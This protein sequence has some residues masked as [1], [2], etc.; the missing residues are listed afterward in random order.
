MIFWTTIFI[1]SL[2]VLVK[3]ADWLLESAEKIGLALGLSPFIVG[4]T[5]VGVGTSFPELVS[6]FAAALKNVGEIVPAN[7]IG[8]NIANI[9]L[10]VGAS[11]VV[12]YR[13]KV[14]KSL[15]DLDL[16]LLAISTV[17]LL[18]VAW[19]K[20]ITVGESLILVVVYLV[21]LLHTI[22][23]EESEDKSGYLAEILPSRVERRMHVV[24]PESDK[25]KLAEKPK[26]AF[27]DFIYLALGIIGL[28]FGAKYLI[29]SVINLSRIFAVGVG[30]ISLAAVALGT[31]LPELFV[32]I[33]AAWQKKSEV[34]LGNIFGSNVFNMLA[35]VGIPGLLGTLS[36]DD[37]T[38]SLGLPVLAAAT[39]L[40]VISGISRRI[41]FWEGLMYLAIYAFFIGKL[42]GIL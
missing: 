7:A 32:S 11:A 36:L 19:D 40:F 16:P 42:F 41:H 18:G 17:L 13:I 12:G 4:V 27:A 2:A 5:I 1:A 33:K 29:D 34:A 37:K 8:S 10:V 21:Y 3:G 39:M 28:L 22:F 25:Q 23:H 20:E 35:V 14:T 24:S 15:I 26:L 9:L 6:A 31:S 30:V 38:F